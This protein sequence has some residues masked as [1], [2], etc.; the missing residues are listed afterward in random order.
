MQL[1][2]FFNRTTSCDHLVLC[3]KWSSTEVLLCVMCKMEFYLG[4]FICICSIYS[5]VV[6]RWHLN[7]KAR[8][9]AQVRARRK[10][11]RAVKQRVQRMT[12][13][14]R[15]KKAAKLGDD[16]TRCVLSSVVTATRSRFSSIITGS[17]MHCKSV[18]MSCSKGVHREAC[19]RCCTL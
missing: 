7:V 12:T 17:I 2:W 9:Q 6:C 10:V 18:M 5:A 1:V 8:A 4:T 19:R 15:R 13:A 14:R 3:V 16:Q 11:P